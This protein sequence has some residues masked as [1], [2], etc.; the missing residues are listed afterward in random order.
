MKEDC[1]NQNPTCRLNTCLFFSST[2]LAR[3]F[4]KIGEEA[5]KHIGLS[6]SLAMLIYVLNLTD[7]IQQKELGERLYL[8]PS[9]ITR[10]I[11]KLTY[12]GLVAKRSEGKNVFV[13]TTEQGKSLQG[14]IV[15]AW[16]TLHILYDGILTEEESKQ[17]INI[18]N[19]LLEKLGK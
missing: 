4:S 18:S 5:F 2:K 19:K 1:N 16:N 10:F 15:L 12:K 17:F 13:S 14:E 9:T 3:E 6:P 7:E 8:T 11:E